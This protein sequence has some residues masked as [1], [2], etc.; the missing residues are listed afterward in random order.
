MSSSRPVRNLRH[1]GVALGPLLAAMSAAFGQCPNPDHNCF[2]TG[3]AGCSDVSCCQSVCS[4]DPFCC[5]NTWDSICVDE[6]SDLCDGCG[7]PASGS[8]WSS[9]GTPF[10]DDRSCCDSV[11][12]DDPFCCTNS[13]D[14]ICADEAIDMCPG[15][16]NPEAGD[17][18]AANGSPFCDNAAC[19]ELVCA[20]DPFCC[21]NTWDSV[22]AN[23]AVV[24]PACGCPVPECFGARINFGVTPDDA[25]NPNDCS[26]GAPI[27]VTTQ[28]VN[29]NGIVFGTAVDGSLPEV[30]ILGDSACEFPCRSS[31]LPE[32]ASDWWAGFRVGTHFGGVTFF[33][34]ELCFIDGSLSMNGFDE[35]GALIATSAT[36]V[37]G[38]E[39][40]T[41]VAPKGQFLARIQVV[42]SAPTRPSGVSVDC[43][44]YDG[45]Y[46]LGIC[47]PS[48]HN[49]FTSGSMGC[50]D[51]ECCESVCAQDSFCC[52]VFWDGVCVSEASELCDGC[53]DPEA[54]CC[55]DAH[56][57]PYCNDRTCCMLVCAVDP[58]CCDTSWDGIC[59]NGANLQCCPGDLTGDGL[60]DGA[61]LGAFLGGWGQPGTT[62]FT[63]DGVT[64]GPDL[65]ILLGSWGP[66]PE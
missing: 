22:C 42:A 3:G 58:F 43:L 44:D 64:D 34:A 25:G 4:S 24:E 26:A 48:D 19:C 36:T 21:T 20:S 53:G 65:G 16:G 9:H 8:C 38:T 50:M 6:A 35:S 62:D 40:L 54:G 14:S 52:N 27:V 13:W 18:C 7:D 1:L 66:C 49:C 29:S 31:G 2:T 23:E 32:Y 17:C 37:T 11:C 10:C 15:C 5:T 45:P 59:A 12:A 46:D 41:L 30:A 39:T 57:G 28:Y 33:S 63:C 51:Q 56:E 47:P 61:D 60:V 55:Y